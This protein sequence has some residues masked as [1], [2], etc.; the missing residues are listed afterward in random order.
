MTRRAPLA[1]VML[2]AGLVGAAQGA[3]NPRR[4]IQTLVDAGKLA[5]AEQRAR[6]GGAPLSATLGDVLAWRGRLAAAESAYRAAIAANADRRVATVGLA[7]IAA[8]RGDRRGAFARADTIA[9]AFENRGRATWS[10]DDIEAAARAYLL[11]GSDSRW[12]RSALGAFDEAVAEDSSNVDAMI[13]IGDL[14]LNKYNAPDARAQYNLVLKRSPNHPRALLG[15]AN[16]LAFQD[17]SNAMDYVHRALAG[18]PSLEDAIVSVARS[19]LE[20][21]RY[22]SANGYA[23]NALA[24]DSAS[25][26]AWALLGASAWISGDSAGFRAAL[27]GVSRIN[28]RPADFYAELADAATRNRRYADAA[29]LAR[30]AIALDSESVRALGTLGSNLLRAGD[31]PGGRA[32]IERAFALDPY[33]LWHKNTLDLLDALAKFKTIDRGRFRIV[34]PAADAELITTYLFPLLEEAYDTLAKRYDY[35][36]PTPVRL[37]LYGRHADFSV[38]T[39]GLAGLGALGVSFGTTLAMDA[40]TARERGTFNWG[41]TAWHEL[42]HT[43]TLGRSDNRVPRWLSEGLSVFEERRGRPG[44]G[45]QAT[46]EFLAAYKG[47]KLRKP[48]ELNDG[49]VRPRYSE[50]IQFSY[51]LAS[52]V[53]EEVYA[54]R[55][56]AGLVALLDAYRAGL[57]TPAAFQRVLGV[58]MDAFDKKFDQWMFARFAKPLNY[59]QMGDGPSD[60]KG[61]YV[62]A[63]RVG[64]GLFGDNKLDSAK[65][66][67]EVAEA[68]F[69]EYGGQK[70]AAWWLALIAQQRGDLRGAVDQLTRITTRNESAWEANDLEAQLRAQMGDGRGAAAVMDRMIWIWPNDDTLHVRLAE[71]YAGLGDYPHAIRERR[72]VLALNPG[73]RLEARYQLAKALADGGDTAAARKEL[74]S[75]LEQAPNYEKAL[76][77]LLALRGRSPGESL[78]NPSLQRTLIGSNI[79]RIAPLI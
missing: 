13:R 30:Q 23:R 35:R 72:A 63:T 6:A 38:R 8:W 32:A 66:V 7:E 46:V 43:F 42:T 17:S 19:Y 48:S 78:S 34:A 71:L 21:E 15:V 24:V 41:S 18:N 22:D 57:D 50:E 73:D 28:P 14:F 65:R 11:L 53:C 10:S 67:L 36:P 37:E 4:Q 79:Q 68:M 77:L 45:A 16:V 31:I 75:I 52:L 40:P 47:G 64:V 74:L 20:A 58:S 33:N 26:S 69:P 55:G 1:F 61:E 76:A 54:E 56:A 51:Y 12:V 60:P 44:W 59:I 62:S 3:V 29:K 39:V 49:F 25:T 70:S 9:A 27:A 2:C 5:E